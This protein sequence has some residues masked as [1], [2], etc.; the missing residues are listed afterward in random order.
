MARPLRL[1]FAGALYHVT[2]RGDGRE[3]IYL[4][5]GDRRLFL[6][7]LGGVWERFNWSVHVY[8]PMTNHYLCEASH[9]T[10]NV[11]SPIM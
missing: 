5:G 4:A 8:C 9:K 1:E 2:A 7:V 3:D 11:K 6:D 10:C